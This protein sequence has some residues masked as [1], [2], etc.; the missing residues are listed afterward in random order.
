MLQY[1]TCS[2]QSDNDSD[3]PESM[4]PHRLTSQNNTYGLHAGG[5]DTPTTPLG[6]DDGDFNGVSGL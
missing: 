1:K 3:Y 5:R 6:R 4:M 2:I